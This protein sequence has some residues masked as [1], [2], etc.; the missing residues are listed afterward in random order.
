M[1]KAIT[2]FKKQEEDHNAIIDLKKF[3]IKKVEFHMD[4]ER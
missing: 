3:R 2:N 1:S 4:T